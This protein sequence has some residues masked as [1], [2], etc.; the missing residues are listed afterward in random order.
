MSPEYTTNGMQQYPILGGAGGYVPALFGHIKDRLDKLEGLFNST[1]NIV[2]QYGKKEDLPETGELNTLYFILNTGNIFFWN[3]DKYQSTGGTFEF[4]D[5]KGQAFPGPRGLAVE[6]KVREI[7]GKIPEFTEEQQ[8]ALNSGIN[9]DLVAKIGT[10]AGDWQPKLTDAQMNAV[11]SGVTTTTVST[12]SS[13]DTRVTLLERGSSSGGG[14]GGGSNPDVTGLTNRMTTAE[15][16]IANLETTVNNAQDVLESGL[17][18][19]SLEDINRRLAIAA[20]NQ[21]MIVEV[22]SN[23][24]TIEEKLPTM[25]ETIDRNSVSVDGLYDS[26]DSLTTKINEVPNTVNDTVKK[27]VAESLKTI[28]G[29][30]D[31]LDAAVGD[32]DGSSGSLTFRIGQLENQTKNIFTPTTDQLNAMNSGIT[33]EGLGEIKTQIEGIFTPTTNQLDAMN[34]GITGTLVAKIDAKIDDVKPTDSVLSATSENP[35]QNKVVKAELDKKANK[36]DIPSGVAVD[37]ALSATSENPVQNKV[38]KAELDKKAN[39]DD[40][41]SGV[42]VDSAL[43]ATSENPVQNKVVKAELDKKYVSPG[44]DK[45]PKTGSSKLVTSGAVATYVDDMSMA[46]EDIAK[47]YPYYA[48]TPVEFPVESTTAESATFTLKVYNH[49]HNIPVFDTHNGTSALDLTNYVKAGGTVKF[50]IKV[51]QDPP[52]ESTAIE[53]IDFTIGFLKISM[54][55]YNLAFTGLYD[56]KGTTK[57]R[58]IVSANTE[59]TGTLKGDSSYGTFLVFSDIANQMSISGQGSYTPIPFTLVNKFDVTLIGSE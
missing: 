58:D 1:G 34:S 39:K 44:F 33:V 7:E 9:A 46:L 43:S 28:Q 49:R 22:K 6:N 21:N 13:L 25:Q 18:K 29:S 8:A 12:V 59:A 27:E 52:N 48:G 57:I 53:T 14:G 38:V 5:Q 47:V 51:Y 41:P 20:S 40:I 17:T 45:I 4:G 31:S 35:V 36:D 24:R 56:S 37:S 42:A 10:V 16:K 3:G 54:P 50:K 26:V 2:K 15:G 23:V 19:R 30:I 32:P 55:T 11:N